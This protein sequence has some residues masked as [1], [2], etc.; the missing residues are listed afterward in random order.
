MMVDITV[1]HVGAF[2]WWDDDPPSI[3]FHE[4]GRFRVGYVN[5]SLHSGTHIDLPYHVGL[6]KMPKISGCYKAMV[7]PLDMVRNRTLESIQKGVDTILIKTGLGE[8]LVLGSVSTNYPS[9]IGEDA[10]FLMNMGI[11]L[12]GIESPSIE[13]Y[14]GDGSVHSVFLERGIP[15]LETINLSHVGDGI[16]TLHIYTMKVVG[17]AL[18]ALPAVAMLEREGEG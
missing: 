7:I 17:Y 16:Y 9:L 8:S 4:Y 14:D 15:I 12:V 10:D 6:K 18:D 1:P 13:E 2:H 11:K 3:T 5:M